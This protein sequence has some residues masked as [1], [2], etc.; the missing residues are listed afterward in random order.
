[1]ELR[2]LTDLAAI[3]LSAMLTLVRPGN[4]PGSRI[5]VRSCNGLDEDCKPAGF[6]FTRAHWDE[7]SREETSDEGLERYA[8]IALA[9]ANVAK[10]PPVEWHW[11]NAA[12]D[13][14][15]VR[16]EVTIARH[17]SGFWRSVHEGKLRGPAGEVC[18]VQ[19]HPVLARL[20][21]IDLESLVGVDLA[22]TERCFRAG[23]TVL[24]KSRDRA[25]RDAHCADSLRYHWFQ[26]SIALYGSGRDCI[27][28]DWVQRRMRTYARTGERKPLEADALAA[29]GLVRETESL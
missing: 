19:I 17:E 1:L 26:P 23:L 12:G 4:Q 6:R 18:L 11:C 10:A 13:L 7:P 25:E 9:E 3:A 22:A 16:A 24:A 27:A 15:A 28:G 5:A 2:T 21:G 29:L 8:T 20:L 14:Q